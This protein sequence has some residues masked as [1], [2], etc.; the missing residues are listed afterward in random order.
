M[1]TATMTTTTTATEQM[2]IP[3]LGGGKTHFTY[4]PIPLSEKAN[5]AMFKDMGRQVHG[6]NPDTI[7]PEQTQEII[8]ML[9]RVSLPR[10]LLLVA[11]G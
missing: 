4:S 8:E 10:A 6:Y 5:P 1:A 2:S 7:T 9:Y 11:R 3:L